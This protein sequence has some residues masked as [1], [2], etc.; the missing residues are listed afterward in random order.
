MS[1]SNP[2]MSWHLL[3]GDGVHVSKP[4][5]AEAFAVTRR[6]RRRVIIDGH[7]VYVAFDAHGLLEE[8][9]NLGR[10]GHLI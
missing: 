3:R 7:Q 5:A 1:E 2:G 9:Y 10:P 6:V 8:G 4:K